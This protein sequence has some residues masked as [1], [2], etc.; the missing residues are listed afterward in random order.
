MIFI[1]LNLI[2]LCSFGFKNLLSPFFIDL[3]KIKQSPVCSLLFLIPKKMKKNQNIG[4]AI[5]G[6][7]ISYCAK[8]KHLR[9]YKSHHKKDK[10]IDCIQDKRGLKSKRDS[11][12]CQ[13]KEKMIKSRKNE[14]FHT[15]PLL[16]DRITA[17]KFFGWIK[18]KSLISHFLT[19]PTSQHFL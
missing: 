6:Q 10:F 5:C 15:S 13:A 2:S 8:H 14:I 18:R 11:F 12:L 19:N 1:V 3:Q 4:I 9:K 17:Y 16:L 7:T